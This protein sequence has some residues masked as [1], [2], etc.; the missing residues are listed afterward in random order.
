LEQIQR[1]AADEKAQKAA[2]KKEENEAKRA[3]IAAAK[4]EQ[5]LKGKQVVFICVDI[6]YWCT[7]KILR[8]YLSSELCFNGF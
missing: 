7:F 8:F 2:K 4:A 3:A 5:A 1:E 6:K